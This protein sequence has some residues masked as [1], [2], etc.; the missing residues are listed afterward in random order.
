MMIVSADCCFISFAFFDF[1]FSSPDIF[2]IS[3]FAFF[4]LRLFSLFFRPFSLID[5]FVLIIFCFIFCFL[6]LYRHFSF[7]LYFRHAIS[8]RLISPIDY[9]R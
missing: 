2:I 3:F 4:F 8:C 5:Y 7:H 6:C 9:L 1:D